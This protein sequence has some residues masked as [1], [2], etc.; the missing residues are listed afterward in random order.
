MQ[1]CNRCCTTPPDRPAPWRRCLSV[2]FQ[3]FSGILSRSLTSAHWR[4]SH[5]LPSPPPAGHQDLLLQAFE[6]IGFVDGL[7]PV[8]PGRGIG[9]LIVE[10]GCFVP[11]PALQHYALLV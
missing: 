1:P 9:F 11:V 2:A 6:F 10:R 8:L 4:R 5:R 7:L 3:D